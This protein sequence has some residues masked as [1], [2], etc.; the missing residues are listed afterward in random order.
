MAS[1]SSDHSEKSVAGSSSTLPPSPTKSDTSIN[2]TSSTLT[3]SEV[4]SDIK[5]KPKRRMMQ[6]SIPENSREILNR[7]IKGPSRQKYPPELRAFA[8]TLSWYRSIDG[9]PGFTEEA[10]TLLKAKV[11]E[12]ESL[13]QKVL[14]NLVMD[15][16]AIMRRV[17]WTGQKFSGF[18]N[19]G[20][21]IEGDTLP[22]AREALVFML[23]DVN[24]HW[25]VSV[26][27]FLID[28][29]KVNHGTRGRDGRGNICGCFDESSKQLNV[30][31]LRNKKKWMTRYK[32]V[33]EAKEIYR[34]RKIERK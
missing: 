12:Y 6:A 14:Y 33:T 34:S 8:L 25:K 3:A 28:G 30:K 31:S 4:E 7:I 20:T 5:L 22:E 23:V 11:S 17:E 21:T 10:Q 2:K 32:N 29:L 16:I 26:E 18:V 9:S 24:G 19:I 1:E 27:Y 15:E 13:G